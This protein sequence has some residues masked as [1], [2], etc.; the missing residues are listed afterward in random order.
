[1]VP[2]R[3]L[4]SLL[5]LADTCHSLYN[6][7]HPIDEATTVDQT[8]APEH[9]PLSQTE[10]IL[11]TFTAPSKTFTDLRRS[12]SWWLPFLIV[13][14]FSYLF[15]GVITQKIGFTAL[16]EHA[17]QQRAE[18]TGQQIAPEAM[19]KGVSASATVFK[20]SFAASPLLYLIS[21]ALFSL[22][23]WVGFNFLLGGR[24]TYAGMFAVYL[25]GS[26]PSLIKTAITV[27][28]VWFGNT[29][30]FDLQDPVGTNPGFYLG[31]DSAHWL[32][33]FLSCFD[34]FTLWIL[35]LVALGGAILSEVKI[36]SGMILVFG[37]YAAFVLVRT[38]F[39]AF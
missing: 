13:A 38:A 21:A 39:A 32:K 29:E 36:R 11:D 8:L 20:V 16:A 15:T 37:A 14:L 28:V 1:M 3:T 31:S 35:F 2:L 17:M 19:A 33:T 4:R 5:S 10:R 12:T 7:G 9:L 18:E 24:A 26:L 25:F 22:L 6:S 34:I 30:N 23:L 27:A